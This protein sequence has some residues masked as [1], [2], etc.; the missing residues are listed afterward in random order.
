M[1]ENSPWKHGFKALN[2]KKGCPQLYAYVHRFRNH[3][4]MKKHVIDSKVWERHLLRWNKVKDGG[5]PGLSVD[6]Y[7]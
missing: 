4:E 7:N 2:I 6:D 3:P 5:K 1:L